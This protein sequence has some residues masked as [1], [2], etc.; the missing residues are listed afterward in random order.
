MRSLLD[1]FRHIYV[2]IAGSIDD[3][4]FSR[5][6]NVRLLHSKI[7]NHSQP[8]R[9]LIYLLLRVRL[10]SIPLGRLW[11][12]WFHRTRCLLIYKGREIPV[13]MLLWLHVHIVIVVD[14]VLILDHLLRRSLT[15]MIQTSRCLTCNSTRF[16]MCWLWWQSS[17]CWCKGVFCKWHLRSHSLL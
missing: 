8:I 16:M 13:P 3:W 2:L 17:H 1:L 4:V 5:A 10:V 14:E 9:V 15:R 12:I 7:S 11:N 6:D